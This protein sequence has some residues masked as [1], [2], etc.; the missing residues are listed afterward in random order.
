MPE[1]TRDG[2]LTGEANNYDIDDSD[3]SRP[4]DL[5]AFITRLFLLPK[6]GPV[7]P[8]RRKRG[9][10]LFRRGFRHFIQ[11]HRWGR[12]HCWRNCLCCN[13]DFWVKKEKTAIGAAQ[14]P[15]EEYWMNISEG[16]GEEFNEGFGSEGSSESWSEL[17]SLGDTTS[18]AFSDVSFPDT[19]SEAS[20]GTDGEPVAS[21]EQELP[22]EGDLPPENLRR[23]CK[24]C[25]D[26][27]SPGSGMQ[28]EEGEPAVSD[29]VETSDETGRLELTEAVGDNT[30]RTAPQRH[31]GVGNIPTLEEAIRLQGLMDD[32]NDSD[33][34]PVLKSILNWILS[35]L[36]IVVQR[37]LIAPMAILAVISMLVSIIIEELR[38]AMKLFEL[39]N[40]LIL[41]VIHG[42]T[43]F[44]MDLPKIMLEFGGGLIH[45]LK[46]L[47][48]M[49]TWMAHRLPRALTLF[50][51]SLLVLML[52]LLWAI[53]TVIEI[54]RLDLVFREII[55][56]MLELSPR[57]FL[58]YNWRV[59]GA[60]LKVTVDLAT[61]MAPAFYSLIAAILGLGF[62]IS[63]WVYRFLEDGIYFLG[64]CTFPDTRGTSS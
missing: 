63:L 33:P 62:F 26:I 46:K 40:A 61:A 48:E 18:A 42:Y 44:I 24:E 57:Q 11:H 47:L 64:K 39:V 43:T 19:G 41:V 5:N 50:V 6:L 49:I 21:E 32:E 17:A 37:L 53:V 34:D 45:I 35:W 60:L 56:A 22:R 9:P 25:K 2:S 10:T 38:A 30:T 36:L 7:G 20:Y 13:A 31:H 15:R 4:I 29:A 1:G 16:I 12:D 58:T 28:P 23:I 52:Y 51:S 8:S 3:R 55:F 59:L 54:D 14:G 27:R